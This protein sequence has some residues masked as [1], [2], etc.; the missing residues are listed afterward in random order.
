MNPFVHI[1]F[2]KHLDVL[3]FHH[4]QKLYQFIIIIYLILF[5]TF[6]SNMY[7][8]EWSSEMVSIQTPEMLQPINSCMFKTWEVLIP[9]TLPWLCVEIDSFYL[10][11]QDIMK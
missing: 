4:I 7:V 6:I 11:L 8:E 9:I 10:Q 1:G 2:A 3:R 5:S